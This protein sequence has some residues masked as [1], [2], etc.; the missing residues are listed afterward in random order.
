[1]TPDLH[2]DDELQALLARAL[3]DADEVPDAA[4][5]A[6]LAAFDV[7]RLDGELARL[8]SDSG[9]RELAGVRHDGAPADRL[10]SFVWAAGTIEVDLPGD[11]PVVLG[12]L[13]PPDVATV[14]VE[15]ADPEGPS[16]EQPVA[17]D[18]LGRFRLPVGPGAVRLRLD[19]AAGPVVTS[20]ITR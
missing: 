11:E 18:A 9:G 20:W 16:H 13:D 8:V 4:V 19:T 12:Q 17:V 5:A 2:D 15:V 1:M 7:G 10:L 3:R 14:V 6:A